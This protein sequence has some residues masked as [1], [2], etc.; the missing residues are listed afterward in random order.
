MVSILWYRKKFLIA[1]VS[2]RFPEIFK[3]VG[4]MVCQAIMLTDGFVEWTQ[5]ALGNLDQRKSVQQTG[6][7]WELFMR[8]QLHQV[9]CH[10]FFSPWFYIFKS[11]KICCSQEILTSTLLVWLRSLWMVA[12]LAKHSLALLVASS[13]TSGRETDSS[14]QT[15][16]WKVSKNASILPIAYI[17]NHMSFS[18]SNPCPNSH[19]APPHHEGHPLREHWYCQCS[20]QRVLAREQRKKSFFQLWQC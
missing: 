6:H 19:L 10:S 13:G 20:G 1:R 18:F 11:M 17:L 12:L 3:E 4:N 9:K 2:F 14:S 15:K 7:N 8:T 5:F 16:D